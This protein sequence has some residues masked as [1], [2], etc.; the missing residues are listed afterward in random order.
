MSMV[1]H[2]KAIAYRSG[3][4]LCYPIYKLNCK[5]Y[6]TFLVTNTLAYF[7]MQLINIVNSFI[8]NDPGNFTLKL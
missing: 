5:Y 2:P 7:A 1:F 3:A 8:A 6:N 4:S